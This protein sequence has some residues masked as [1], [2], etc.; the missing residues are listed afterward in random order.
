[1]ASRCFDTE[2]KYGMEINMEQS[3]VMRVS[4]RNKSLYIKAGNREVKEVD[5][6]KY[7][8]SELTSDDYCTREIKTRNAMAKEAFNKTKIPLLNSYERNWL[9]V[10]FGSLN[11]MTLRL[12]TDRIGTKVFAEFQ[13]VLLVENEEHKMGRARER[14]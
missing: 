11:C 1:M 14:E 2:S 5:N 4:R 6:I 7:L 10:I 8:E 9:G 3:Q 13:N 12:D